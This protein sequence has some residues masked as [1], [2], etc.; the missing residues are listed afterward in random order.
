MNINTE[1][2][3]DNQKMALD[4][5][6]VLNKR[7]LSLAYLALIFLGAAG[8]H[9][10]YL[11]RYVHGTLYLL[12]LSII[13]PLNIFL[14]FIPGII[15]LVLLVVD[16]ILLPLFTKSANAKIK[17]ELYLK[18]L[19]FNQALKINNNL[20]FNMG[21]YLKA[22]ETQIKK[23]DKITDMELV[24]ME[25]KIQDINNKTTLLVYNH[26]ERPTF[27]FGDFLKQNAAGFVA[28][29]LV[30]AGLVYFSYSLKQTIVDASTAAV[31]E[32][33]NS[34]TVQSLNIQNSI[35][36]SIKVG[37]YKAVRDSLDQALRKE[38]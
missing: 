9:Q 13:I 23:C 6:F 26:G 4:I 20:N 21:D 1:L 5:L 7:K 11:K 34:K 27:N 28:I 37:V 29:I 38:Q 25:E 14:F 31:N 17:T 12:L 8:V 16:A 3:D 10:F 19:T 30:F 32:A 33:M 2:L 15:M 24:K 18:L 36:E 35:Q 22:L